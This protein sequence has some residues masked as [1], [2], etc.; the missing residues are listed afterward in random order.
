MCGTIS[1]CE[2]N[3]PESHHA[4]DLQSVQLHNQIPNLPTQ[5][6]SNDGKMKEA[7]INDGFGDDNV[8]FERTPIPTYC[9]TGKG[10]MGSQGQW[11]VWK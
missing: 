7:L 1:I 3:M 11:D 5:T 8:A 9:P 2:S 10:W 6:R 4:N